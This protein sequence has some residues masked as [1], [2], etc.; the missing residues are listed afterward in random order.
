[1]MSKNVQQQSG[2]QSFRESKK[3]RKDQVDQILAAN[4]LDYAPISNISVVDK[5][6][7]VRH[8][9]RQQE[10]KVSNASKTMEI[11]LGLG[12][13]FVYAPNCYLSFKL[14]VNA[15]TA[16]FGA[17]S[18]LSL[19]QTAEI[20]A[21]SGNEIDRV[22]QVNVHSLQSIKYGE[23]F[24][25]TQTG[26]GGL[27][28]FSDGWDNVVTTNDTVVCIP[29]KFLLPCFSYPGLLP[30]QGFLA[31]SV[32]RLELAPATIGLVLNG[33]TEYTIS[34]PRIMMDELILTDAFSKRLQL[35]S[36]RSGPGL[37]IT[38]NSWYHQQQISNAS[39][40]VEV[41]MANSVSRATRAWCMIRNTANQVGGQDSISALSAAGSITEYQFKL[42]NLRFPDQVSTDNSEHFAN[43]L[44]AWQQ[45][46]K[47]VQPGVSLF[48]YTT[49][50]ADLADGPR[51][52]SGNRIVAS[53]F[54]R[55][56][57]L[58]LSG[59]GVN[60]NRLLRVNLEKEATADHTVDLFLE[61]VRHA[62]IH[63]DLQ[64]IST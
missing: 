37:S 42:G 28:G 61:Y 22:E 55:N 15:G 53:S 27:I 41:Q 1:M 49:N 25:Y 26:V 58:Q 21:H 33:S 44:I 20:K 34:D 17:H 52:N 43:A 51:F 38:W 57:I 39:A 9:F 60:G 24:S 29:M 45:F 12:D 2:V 32:I 13:A 36:A 5:R 16:G 40:R 56:H 50:P 10:Y 18:A 59:I 11:R 48:G 62:N 31:G 63:L 8:E 3:G 4:F 23:S 30:S 14:K 64:F 19:F 35:M 47:S 7:Q 46:D 6:S 54:E